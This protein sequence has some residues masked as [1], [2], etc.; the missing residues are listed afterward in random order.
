MNSRTY[1]LTDSILVVMDLEALV[2][3]IKQFPGITRKH[4]IS[5]IINYLPTVDKNRVLAS[6]GE[7]AAVIAHNDECL[8]LAADGI[9]ESL[10][11]TDPCYAGYFAVLV[12]INDIAAMGGTPGAMVNI[13][14]M[15]DERVCAQ[16]MKGIERAVKKF[17][18]PMVGGHTH[19]DCQ[20]HAIDVAILGSVDKDAVIFSHT[21]QDGDDILF[22]MDLEG[23][24]PSDLPYAWDTTTRKGVDIVR[25]QFDVM[26]EIGKKG[27]AT[28][29]KDMSNPGCIG[30]LGM[31]L[32]TSGMG[33]DVN[34]DLIPRPDNV[35]FT[36]WALSYQGC[37]FVL[38]CRPEHSKEIMAMFKK[39]KVDGAVVGKVDPSRK[40]VL[41]SGNEE[42]VLF[43]FNKDIIT[44][45]SPSTVFE[46]N[47][48]GGC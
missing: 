8:L 12:N 45:C 39:V 9:M 26:V 40:L 35:D 43:D 38:T 33:G 15:K 29:G 1:I 48:R 27:I 7:D 18:V 36:Q 42:R 46:K 3:A 17:G 34:V 19:P 21:A 5:T 23:F 13:I 41:R 14:S 31:L 20:Y 25:A 11:K 24:Y 44:G 32:E 37:G 16:V 28:A 2:N 10:M 6:A 4:T 22:L 30:T 47:G